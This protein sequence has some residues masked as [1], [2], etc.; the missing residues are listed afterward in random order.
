M[1]SKVGYLQKPDASFEIYPRVD[2]DLAQCG[3]DI[4][5]FALDLAECGWAPAEC[6]WAPA[7]CGWDSAEHGWDLAECG[8]DLAECKLDLA[9]EEFANQFL[10]LASPVSGST[11]FWHMIKEY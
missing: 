11:Q 3:W 6:G 7:E 9:V 1:K 10:R 4:A 5:E 8:R 2:A